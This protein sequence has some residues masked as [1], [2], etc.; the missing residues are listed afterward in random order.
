VIF[1]APVFSDILKTFV[2]SS[3][4]SLL[5]AFPNSLVSSN[6]EDLIRIHL[7]CSI[8][9]PEERLVRFLTLG[10][11]LGAWIGAFPIPLDWDTWWQKWPISC[12][13][14]CLIGATISLIFFTLAQ[15]HSRVRR[16]KFY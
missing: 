5:V 13:F 9:S 2:F 16:R 15:N 8:T 3:L 1:G 10:S 14:G 4:L 11:L 6:L 7:Q 12:V